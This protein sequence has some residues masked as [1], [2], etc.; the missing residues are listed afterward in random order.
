M[1]ATMPNRDRDLH[2]VMN[3]A[4][5]RIAELFQTIEWTGFGTW[6]FHAMP[7]VPRMGD[8]VT[9]S[10]DPHPGLGDSRLGI[11]G[12]GFLDWDASSPGRGKTD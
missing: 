1:G 11:P 7:H 10:G 6:H 4:V 9:F 5:R 2:P 3:G 8:A 12:L